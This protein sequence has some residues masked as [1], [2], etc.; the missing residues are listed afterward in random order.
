M[1]EVSARRFS[2]FRVDVRKIPLK[3]YVFFRRNQR[4]LE[5]ENDCEYVFARV[6]IM[7]SITPKESNHQS[8]AVCGWNTRR[9]HDRFLFMLLFVATLY[10][11]YLHDSSL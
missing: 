5:L 8:F 11:Y 7:C 4:G 9:R 2:R 6:W 10:N 3:C 1:R